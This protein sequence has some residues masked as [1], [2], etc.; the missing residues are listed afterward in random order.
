MQVLTVVTGALAIVYGLSLGWALVAIVVGNV[1]GAAFMALHS[2]Q[3]P[4]LGIPQMIQSRAQ[5]GYFGSILPM[6]IAIG[7]YIGFFFAVEIL[8]GEAVSTLIGVSV[9]LGIILTGVAVFVFAVAG[10]RVI[11]ILMRVLTVLAT[12][13]FVY[14]TIKVLAEPAHHAAASTGSVATFLVV[15]SLVATYQIGYAAYVSDYSR[16]LPTNTPARATFWWSYS[17]TT[18][19]CLWL[20]GLGAL[21]ANRVGSAIVDNPI[22]YFSHLVPAGAAATLVIIVLFAGLVGPNVLNVYGPY[23]TAATVIDSIRTLRVR[24]LGRGIIMVAVLVVGSLIAVDG[25]GSFATAYT[26]F[27][28]IFLYI[29]I[30][31]TSINLTD[32]YLLRQGH[33]D[34]EDMFRARGPYGLVNSSGLTAYLVAAAVEVPFMSTTFYEGPIAHALGG[35][36]ITWIVGLVIAGPL[37]YFLARRSRSYLATEVTD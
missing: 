10:Y 16:Y 31:W 32:F 8:A 29:F 14:L 33:Y 24:V 20:M 4:R 7:M 12:L 27:L 23:I 13:L 18:L 19:S 11:H 2:V 6:F 21:I 5:F 15:L 30:P 28:L 3:G 26:D 36:D 1:V 37:Y 25:S 17:G 34:I 22:G 9:T 35:G